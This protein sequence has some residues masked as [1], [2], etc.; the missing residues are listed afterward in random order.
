RRGNVKV[1]EEKQEKLSYL[2]PEI[3]QMQVMVDLLKER[4]VKSPGLQQA[5]RARIIALFYKYVSPK[6]QREYRDNRRGKILTKMRE[7]RERK[8]EVED[9]QKLVME[10]KGRSSL[11]SSTN[12]IEGDS[13]AAGERL[14]PP[15][16]C[17]NPERKVIKLSGTAKTSGSSLDFIVIKRRNSEESE[18]SPDSKVQRLSP[19]EKISELKR[20]STESPENEM[21]KLKAVNGEEK[22]PEKELTENE[23]KLKQERKL[24]S[25]P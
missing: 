18:P 24:I 10:S 5:D 12:T 14:K 16:S 1:T 25:W 20:K 6:H 11:L 4:G 8:T 3:L 21:K 15:P 19:G 22:S 7:K 9:W 23:K 2:Q 13:A 17:I